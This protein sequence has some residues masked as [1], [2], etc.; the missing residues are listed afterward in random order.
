VEGSDF[1]EAGKHIDRKD[2]PRA[3]AS[4]APNEMPR[5][6]YRERGKRFYRRGD[7][8]TRRQHGLKVSKQSGQR[9]GAAMYGSGMQG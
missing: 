7:N 4:E 6:G 5:I 3:S 2:G 8:R 9:G 1:R